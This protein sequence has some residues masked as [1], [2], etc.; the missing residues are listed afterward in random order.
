MMTY[1]GYIGVA[2]VDDEAGVIRGKVVNTRDTITFQ[3]KSV[4]EAR[5]AFEDSVDDYLEFCESL[6]E[7]PE[8]PFSGKFLVRLTPGVHRD[9]AAVAQAKGLSV[10]KLV[11]QE[12]ARLARRG[13][14]AP[15]AETPGLTKTPSLRKKKAKSAVKTASARRSGKAVPE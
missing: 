7:A 12:L 11:A 14:D 3:G 15:A 5:T 10:N 8:K 1:K 4:D 6:G 9:L 13:V 2:R